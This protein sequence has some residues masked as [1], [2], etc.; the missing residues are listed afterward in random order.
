MSKLPDTLHELLEVAIRDL[1][2]VDKSEDYE[3]DMTVWYHTNDKCK[4][5]MAG[6]VM[7]KTLNFGP[8]S[9]DLGDIWD[10]EGEKFMIIDDLRLCNI[11]ISYN[12]LYNE[13]L[14]FQMKQ[15]IRTFQAS[16]HSH[17]GFGENNRDHFFEQLD[18]IHKFLF[19][20]DL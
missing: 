2:A 17:L 16:L 1:K 20:H 8:E 7:A 15:E 6:A 3:I 18:E 19:K 5:C 12:R 9:F 11:E 14:S 13:Q 10:E 4:V